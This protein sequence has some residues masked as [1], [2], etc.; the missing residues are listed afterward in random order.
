MYRKTYHIWR[1]FPDVGILPIHGKSPHVWEVFPYIGR[2]LIHGKSTLITLTQELQ[3]DVDCEF[4]NAELADLPAD[5]D[6]PG[7]DSGED[8]FKHSGARPETK[9]SL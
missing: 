2:L 5:D 3:P 7:D 1:V 6:L 4:G 9:T 8:I